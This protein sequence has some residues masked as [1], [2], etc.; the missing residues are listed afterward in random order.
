M[1]LTKIN[2]HILLINNFES[3]H[4]FDKRIHLEI[5]KSQDGKNF[6]KICNI[7]NGDEVWFYP[8]AYADNN[9]QILYVAY[10][11][12]HEHRLCKISYS[13]LGI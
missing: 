8:H 12:S 5:H 7:E 13:E 11:N 6:E 9:Q 1:T 10:E 4:R 3:E 2:G